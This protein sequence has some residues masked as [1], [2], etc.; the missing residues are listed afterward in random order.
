M[1][2]FAI[3]AIISAVAAVGSA[4]AGSVAQ[5]RAQDQQDQ[6]LGIENQ[7]LTNAQSNA[8]VQR[9]L[10]QR[11][12]D[13][14]FGT[15]VDAQG[16]TISYDPGS[17]TWRASLSPTA[18]ALQG[19]AQNEEYRRN[20]TDADM[21]RSQLVSNYRRTQSAS[22]V[23]E[24]LLRQLQL[25]DQYTR[26]GVTGVLDNAALTGIDRSFD[27]SEANALAQNSREGNSTSSGPLL[28][29]M[30]R[31]RSDRVSQAMAQDASQGLQLAPQLNT[32][33]KQAIIDRL[34]SA[35]SMAT[36]PNPTQPAVN[37][38]VGSQVSSELASRAGGVNG[39][40]YTAG[41]LTQGATSGVNQA[42][43]TAG[44]GSLTASAQPNYGQALGIRGAVSGVGSLAQMLA[45]Y[46]QKNGWLSSE[47]T[48]VQPAQSTQQSGTNDYF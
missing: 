23:A 35:V 26:Q 14:Q 12:M 24:A 41:M 42:T 44:S 28:A 39:A 17:H 5:K 20:T 10:S 30:A 43:A 33:A 25:P 18:Q 22:N 29:E 32:Q 45:N 16:N 8:Q 1:V 46:A 47:T 13:A 7:G 21:I 48:G 37:D 34:G 36:A 15:M 27:L 19:A 4:V 3:P 38:S 2:W 31:A 9:E 6:A 40:G 11:I